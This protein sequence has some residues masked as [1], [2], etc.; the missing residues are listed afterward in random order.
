MGDLNL[1]CTTA[2]K[3]SYYCTPRN[4]VLVIIVGSIG[5]SIRPCVIERI[6]YTRDIKHCDLMRLCNNSKRTPAAKEQATWQTNRD[7]LTQASLP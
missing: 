5:G 2:T 6:S 3:T 1:S 4:P 7:L